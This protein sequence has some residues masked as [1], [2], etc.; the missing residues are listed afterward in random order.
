MPNLTTSTDVDTFMQS[1]DKAAMRTALALGT[2]ATANTGDFA[3]A[4]QGA[5]ADSAVQPA[6]LGT[7]AAEDVGYFATAAQGAKADSA[8]QPA[9]VKS[10]NFTAANDGLYVV[11]AS[12]TIT[13]PSPTEGKGYTVIVRNGTATIGGTGYST[14]G[15][16]IRR[17]FHSG[18][19]ST[20]VDVLTTDARL[21]DARTPTSHASSHVTGGSD[22]I[23][24]ASA[25]Q[26]GLMTTAYATKLDGI[27]AAADVT[28]AANVGS[29]IH[30][31]TEKTTPVDADTMPLIDSAASNVLK[32]VTWANIKATLK[33]YLDTLYAKIGSVSSSGLT[34]T[35]ARLLGRTTAST[36]AVE[37]LTAAAATAFLS[38]M[39]G[40][41]GSGGTKGLVPAPAAGDAAGGKVLHANGTWAAPASNGKILQVIQ[42]TKT[43][44][45]SV[46]GTTFTSLFSASITPSSS[47]STVLVIA[48][49]NIGGATSNWPLI[50]LTR[51]ST[52]LLQGDAASNRVRVTTV[53]GAPNPATSVSASI[54]YLDSPASTSALT[55]NIEVASQST[56]TIYMN[57][58]FTDTDTTAFQRGASTII[59]M[60]VA[61]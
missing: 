48:T 14:A 36:G 53:C 45:A 49:L 34:M 41:S 6:D 23:R 8:L 10:S 12:A 24:D 39:V 17:L 56:G 13:D 60:E 46:T 21:S 35:T 9:E 47:S 15:S 28:D 22:K 4:A 42:T 19:W 3:T 40:D 51:S 16:Q 2:A 5:K 18:G 20:Y 54:S 38:A 32:K 11:T 7:A 59:L 61:A 58:S 26:D 27:E 57:R 29:S 37:E 55:Y 50:R 1:A 52:T 25:S 43:D 44:T 31:A 33:T 30:G